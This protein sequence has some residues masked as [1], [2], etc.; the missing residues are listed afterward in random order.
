MVTSF[1]QEKDAAGRAIATA[2]TLVIKVGSA[3]LF[4]GD[5]VRYAWLASLAQDIAQLA[6]RGARA[7]IVSSGAIALGRARLGLEGKLRLDEKQAA[8]A[9]GQVALMDAWQAAFT[10]YGINTAQVLLTLED[11]DRRRRYL[12]AR[13]TLRALMEH[14]AQPIINE[15]DTVATAE[16]RYGDNDRLA[17]HVAQLIG[18]ST[19]VM[20]SDIDGLYPEDPGK[21]P[22]VRHIP[23]IAEITPEIEAMAAGPNLVA[24]VGSGGMATKIEAAKIAANT[25]C[26]LSLIHI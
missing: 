9:A 15:N 14:K 21:N 11:N 20:L 19:L 16:I 17:A 13:A 1:E 23:Y 12:N 5:V 7:V 4:D 6:D 10:T 24:G 2:K 25:G 8:S 18:A 3:I 22:A 26:G